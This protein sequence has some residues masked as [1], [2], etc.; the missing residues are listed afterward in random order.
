MNERSTDLGRPLDRV[1]LVEDSVVDSE[2]IQHQLRKA[3][4]KCTFTVHRR[5]SEALHALSGK[6][7]FDLILLDLGLPDNVGLEALSG[8]S[9]GSQDSHHRLNGQG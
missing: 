3:G 5:L 1:L 6:G 7:K 4:A 2:L 9:C 8:E